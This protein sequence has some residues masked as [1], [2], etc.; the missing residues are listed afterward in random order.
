MNRSRL[1][2][3][4]LGAAFFA[5]FSP[6]R[7]DVAWTADIVHSRAEFLVSHLVVSK[8]WGHIPIKSL[9][10]ATD[11][12]GL[13]TSLDVVLAPGHLDTDNH[14]RDAD[15]RS[16]SYFD[17]EQ[18][19]TMTFKS[20]SV[21]ATGKTSDG[22]TSFTCTGDLTIKNVTKPVVLTGT[23][24]GRVPDGNSMERIGYTASTTI[25]RR[26]FGLDD[27]RMSP[28]GIPLVGNDVQITLTVEAT[29][30]KG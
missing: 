23:I 6:A 12:S 13:P 4:A 25:D 10:I 9:D 21:K 3:L 2:S 15:L 7:A 27:A 5:G 16:A 28:G 14:E 30:L 17:I 26:A 1:L 19:P 24:E 22:R 18:Y 29:R 8:V 20:A 11:P